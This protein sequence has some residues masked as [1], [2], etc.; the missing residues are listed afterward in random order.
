MA[1]SLRAARDAD[2]DAIVPL[3]NRAFLPERAFI[4]GDRSDADEVR[5]LM[6]SGGFLLAEDDGALVGA[7]YVAVR[8]ERGYL[9]LLS[10]EPER[11]GGGVGR[12]LVA[13][14]EAHCRARGCVA[15]DLRVVNLR[16]ELPPYY[17]RLGYAEVGT[18]EFPPSDSHLL[19]RP[20]HFILMS[21]RLTA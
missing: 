6:A 8:G 7:I 15:M 10:V 21:R 19:R 13:A 20:C 12:T 4:D 18:M 5:Q 11:Q 3:I 1:I 17:R 2:V 9:G 16:E 14:A